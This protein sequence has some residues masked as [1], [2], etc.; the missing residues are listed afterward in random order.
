LFIPSLIFLLST[1]V[2]SVA[3]AATSYEG[4]ITKSVR[5]IDTSYTLKWFLWGFT[6]STNLWATCLIF[7]RAWQHRRFL[8][9][10][11]GKENATS[12]AE[13]GLIFLVESG[14]LYLCIWVTFIITA[15]VASPVVLLFRTSIVELVG[16]YPT[17]IFVVVTM[18]M[19]A[20]DI[21]SHP[22]L[23]TRHHSSTVI[24]APS[25]P[26]VQHSMLA[27]TVGSSSD[28][29]SPVVSREDMSTKTLAPSDPEKG[30]KIVE[31]DVT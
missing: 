19:S 4:S 15:V 22:G 13:R 31:Q 11:F 2:L 24:F 23:E 14:A 16:I 17:A 30:R 5:K 9:H 7:I 20:A 21:L 26:T 12:K 3:A 29:R 8:R 6:I 1:L 28:S 27:M 10:H 25:S 18:Q